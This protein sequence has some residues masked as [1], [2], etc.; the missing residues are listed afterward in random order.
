MPN[1]FCLVANIEERIICVMAFENGRNVAVSSLPSNPAGNIF[2][3]CLSV[4]SQIWNLNE[5]PMILLN[6]GERIFG[7]GAQ[8]SPSISGPASFFTEDY[9]K[10]QTGTGPSLV[11]VIQTRVKCS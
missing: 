7:L 5:A 1:N 3:L 9:A 8:R 6:L 10:S 4:F 2:I 11:K